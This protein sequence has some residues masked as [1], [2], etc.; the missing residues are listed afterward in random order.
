MIA[1]LLTAAEVFAAV[2]LVAAACEVLASVNELRP[3]S[4]SDEVVSAICR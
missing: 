2:A 3:R 1:G 4:R